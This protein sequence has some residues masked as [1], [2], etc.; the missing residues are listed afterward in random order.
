MSKVKSEEKLYIVVKHVGFTFIVNRRVKHN[1]VHPA[2]LSFYR[3][4]FLESLVLGYW[5]E[6][7]VYL[8]KSTPK[9]A[10]GKFVYKK[11]GHGV[12]LCSDNKLRNCM[13]VMIHFECD[14]KAYSEV[15]YVDNTIRYAG[16]MGNDFMDKIKAF[17]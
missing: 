12:V 14:G 15:F 16:V 1:L 7:G 2:Y 10:W 5:D 17:T 6:N 11:I 9:S 8:D 3:Q 4:F 13:R